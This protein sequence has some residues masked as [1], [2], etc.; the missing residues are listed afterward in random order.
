MT[1]LNARDKEIQTRLQMRASLPETACDL[2]WNTP[3]SSASMA[4]TKMLKPI[5]NQIGASINTSPFCI[6]SG[7][8]KTRLH[9]RSV[10][11]SPVVFSHVRPADGA[12]APCL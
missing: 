7:K 5:H 1:A 2:R 8:Q 3:R 4:S 10:V 6:G 11:V 9:D 12:L